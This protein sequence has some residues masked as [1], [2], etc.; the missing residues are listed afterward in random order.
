MLRQSGRAPEMRLLSARA[1]ERSAENQGRLSAIADDRGRALSLTP[2]Y[3]KQHTVRE[4]VIT[5]ET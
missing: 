3:T 4:N 1:A 5:Q 2:T